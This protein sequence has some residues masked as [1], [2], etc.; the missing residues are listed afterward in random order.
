MAKIIFIGFDEE[1]DGLYHAPTG[2]PL[3][4]IVKQNNIPLSFECEDG[5]CGS[6]LINIQNIEDKEPTV[7]IDDKELDKLIELGVLDKKE[8]EHC[9]QFTISPTTRLACQTIVRGDMIVKQFK[10]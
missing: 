8:A 3:L 2:E 4:R 9:Q 10:D 7:Y 6:C 5:D 1:K